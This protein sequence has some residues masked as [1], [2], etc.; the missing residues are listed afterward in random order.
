ML[1]PNLSDLKPICFFFCPLRCLSQASKGALL[2]GGTQRLRWDDYPPSQILLVLFNGQLNAWLESD[3]CH[4]HLQLIGYNCHMVPVKGGERP[5]KYNPTMCLDGKKTGN[6]WW[7]ALPICKWVKNQAEWRPLKVCCMYYSP[8]F[9]SP[10]P[11]LCPG[12][13]TPGQSFF[14]K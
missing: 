8:L 7:T 2:I 6:I 1:L 5:R 12:S 11:I 3:T 9:L 10:S 4:F 14:R 13:S